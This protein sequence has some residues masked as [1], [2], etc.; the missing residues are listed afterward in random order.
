MVTI[1]PDEI[2][3]AVTAHARTLFEKIGTIA[4]RPLTSEE[5]E[6]IL[7]SI[8]LIHLDSVELGGA[9]YATENNL[10]TEFFTVGDGTSED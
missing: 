1:H 5:M 9:L 4:G 7:D 6:S 3:K 8:N 2:K 10:V